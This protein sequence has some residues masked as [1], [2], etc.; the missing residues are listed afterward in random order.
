MLNN[1]RTTPTTLQCPCKCVPLNFSSLTAAEYGDMG[2]LLKRIESRKQRQLARHGGD[3]II[4]PLH[5]AAQH[6]HTELVA[7]LLCSGLYENTMNAKVTP[8][9]RACYTGATTTVRILLLHYDNKTKTCNDSDSNNSILLMRDTSFNDCQTPLHK[10]ASGG[11]YLVVQLL[12]E[13][14]FQ[15][16]NKHSPILP[17]QALFAKDT[18]GNTPLDVARMK[19]RQQEVEM[20]NVKRWDDVAGGCANWDYCV[21]VRAF[22]VS[23][24]CKLTLR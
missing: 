12:L 7:M 9:H 24:I 20:Q 15:Y 21:Q 4:T 8:L 17:S 10:C 19:Q 18:F 2:S 11:R 23:C 5:V 16:N 1:I 14:I 3:E 22:N 6:G 13:Y